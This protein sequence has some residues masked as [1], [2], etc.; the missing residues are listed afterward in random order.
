MKETVQLT[1]LQKR[2]LKNIVKD[3][4]VDPDPDSFGSAD[5]DPDPEVQ[6]H[7]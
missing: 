7:W 5:P 3:S 4:D 6:N 1:A 2:F